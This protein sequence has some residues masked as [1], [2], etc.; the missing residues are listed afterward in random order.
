MDAIVVGGG[1]AGAS[2]A[3][4]LAR[5][6]VRTHLFDR[7]DEGRA[8]A[9]GAGIVSPPTS[10]R[11]SSD[12]WYRFG[13]DAASYYRDLDA[14]LDRVVS[15][16]GFDE[17]PLLSV[18]LDEEGA[19]EFDRAI[20]RARER[21]ASESAP[22]PG[23]VT[24]LSASEAR[25]QFP[26]LGDVARAAR[27]ER[28]AR[29]DGREF[30]AAL[31]AAG[32]REG[33]RERTASVERIRVADGGVTGVVADEFHEADA[34]VVAGGAWSGAFADDLG[35]D[36]SV[37]PM[38]GQLVHLETEG[39]TDEWPI[40]S[41]AEHGYL[42]PWRGGRV[43]AGATYE[44][45]SGF[46]P[47]PD[48]SGVRTVLE[49]AERAAPGLAAAA[50]REVRVGLRPASPDGLPLLGPVP[51]VEGAYVA[52]GFGPTGLTVGPY[53]GRVAADLARGET[54]PS[55]CSAFALDRF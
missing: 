23:P 28:A 45:G 9:A 36:L 42:V 32:Q 43:V 48:V 4:H 14:R 20:E 53:A 31:R 27:F 54:P 47:Y 1:I 33:L 34:V 29:V 12:A 5:A 13:T 26:P 7:E 8:T 50:L 41:T 46:R 52:T 19:E 15:E 35:V 44:D 22:D 10:S 39:N 49:R 16:T 25:A 11:T 24:T 3:Y 30:A 55:D 17:R 51:G 2:A 18:A 21:R 40:L 38:R 37:A 6:G